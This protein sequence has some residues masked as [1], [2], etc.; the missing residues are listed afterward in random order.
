MPTETKLKFLQENW[1]IS[2]SF[3]AMQSELLLGCFFVYKR[4]IKRE[5]LIET[6]IAVLFAVQAY[7]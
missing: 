5:D 4:A 1:R 7:C 6:C 2:K 3:V